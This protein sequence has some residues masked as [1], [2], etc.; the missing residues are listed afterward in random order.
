MGF[1]GDAR[2][3]R[4]PTQ[5]ENNEVNM[6]HFGLPGIGGSLGKCG[7]CGEG[8][9]TEILTNDTCPTVVIGGC[10]FVIH[11]KQCLPALKGLVRNGRLS[12][13]QW[14]ALPEQSPLRPKMKEMYEQL[15][16]EEQKEAEI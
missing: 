8:F 3:T 2:Q 15:T 4:W 16:P 12:L 9:I 14:S 7:Y 10:E 1:T 6:N 5:A 13:A 11:A